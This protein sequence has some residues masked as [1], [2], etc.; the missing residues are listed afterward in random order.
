MSDAS[1]E[2]VDR[3]FTA[4]CP[5][6]GEPWLECPCDEECLTCGHAGDDCVCGIDEEREGDYYE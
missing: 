2:L 3:M 6:C 1:D 4:V 5:E